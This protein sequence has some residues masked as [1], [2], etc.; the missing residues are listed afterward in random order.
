MSNGA[1]QADGSFSGAL[2]RTT[3][4]AFNTVPFPQPS[5]TQVG[6]LRVAFAGKDNG[7]LTYSYLGT[8][9][10]KAITRQSFSTAPTC[11]WSAF[12]RSFA[13][14]FQDLWFNPSEPGWGVNVAHQ[15]NILFA[16]LFTYDASGNGMWLVMPSG[17]KSSVGAYSGQLY[18]TRGPAFNASPWVLP[19][20]PNEVVGNMSFTFTDGDHG[21]LTYTVNG[22]SVT[23]SIQRQVFGNLRTDCEP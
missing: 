4:A 22:V 20:N 6:T 5:F 12:D 23:K 18:R 2:Y 3:G 8:N 21:T 17:Q 1:R 13:A 19:P 15:G 10:T 14:N 16:T 9:V 7:T 11:G